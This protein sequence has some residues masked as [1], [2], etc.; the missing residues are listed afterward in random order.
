MSAAWGTMGIRSPCCGIG[1]APPLPPT[2]VYPSWASKIVEVGYIRLRWE[3]AGVRGYGLSFVISAPSPDLLRKSTSPR[4]GE[5]NRGHRQAD[6]IQATS[7]S[8]GSQ[9][10]RTTLDGL[11]SVKKTHQV[12]QRW[13]KAIRGGCSR[14]G[15]RYLPKP[16]KPCS[17]GHPACPIFQQQPRDIT[18]IR[19]WPALWH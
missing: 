1:S 15:R 8:S 6:S 17:G 10:A 4:W 14:S 19:T 3:R 12:A 18:P 9:L 5:V 13:R 2:R 16:G 7:P 11:E